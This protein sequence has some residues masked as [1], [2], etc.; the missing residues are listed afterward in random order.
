MD[1]FDRYVFWL[2]LFLPKDQRDDIIR[3]L[4]EEYRSHVAE[5]EAELGRP[6]NRDEHA[7]LIAQFGHPLLMAARYRPQQYLVGPVLFPFYWPVLKVT[8]ALAIVVH[9]VAGLVMIATGTPF[10]DVARGADQ[11]WKSVLAIFA[12]VTIAFAVL[13]H[14]IRSGA[15]KGWNPAAAAPPGSPQHVAN[16]AV[17]GAEHATAAVNQALGAVNFG[18]WAVPHPRRPAR[19]GRRCQPSIS[20]LLVGVVLSAWWLLAL[21]F[22]A[23]MFGGGAAIL[24]WGADMHRLY[25]V[26]VVAQVITLAEHAVRLM[27][28]NDTRVF[29]IT[30]LVWFATGAAFLYFLVTLDHQWVVWRNPLEAHAGLRIDLINYAFSAAFIFA[31]AC[32][33]IGTVR[34]IARWFTSRRGPRAAHA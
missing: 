5:K 11:A 28:P 24:D 27:R 13:D 26:L 19:P 22:P 29:R 17:T 6:L 30:R 20:G 32:G 23:L 18:L 4:S 9:V 3:E 33:A 16:H 34:R 10:V 8:I 12:W 2:R 7:G 31:V 15:L 21:K 1:L 25:P 14:S